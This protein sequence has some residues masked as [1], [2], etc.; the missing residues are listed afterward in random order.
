MKGGLN[1]LKK[2]TREKKEIS[3]EPTQSTSKWEHPTP[4]RTISRDTIDS[5]PTTSRLGTSRLDSSRLDTNRLDRPDTSIYAN[6]AAE[7][8]TELDREWYNAEESGV[9]DHNPFANYST[10]DFDTNQFQSNQISKLSA[11]QKQYSV[12]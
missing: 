7:Y 6:D 12:I 5:K 4:L 3:R 10:N 2:D 9:S 8:E 1:Y 11:R